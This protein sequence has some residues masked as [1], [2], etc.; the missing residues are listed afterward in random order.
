[1]KHILTI[2]LLLLTISGFSQNSPLVVAEGGQVDDKYLGIDQQFLI[3]DRLVSG[4]DL[5]TLTFDSIPEVYITAEQIFL[6]DSLTTLSNI[7]G[8]TSRWDIYNSGLIKFNDLGTKGLYMQ[9][10]EN[11]SI[12]RVYTTQGGAGIQ[13]LD[14]VGTGIT[15]YGGDI[16]VKPDEIWTRVYDP[17]NVTDSEI[18][19]GF[20]RIE[21]GVTDS[22]LISGLS[23]SEGEDIILAIDTAT[24][25]LYTKTLSASSG[26]INYTTYS[27]GS[28]SST[29]SRLG[30]LPTVVSNPGTG[31]YN[32]QVASGA[33]ILEIDF[34]GNDVN[35]NAGL[36][37]ITID[38]SANSRDRFFT[39]QT[40]Q[41]TTNG[42][43][44]ATA[45]ATNYTQ[46]SS[47]NV[48]TIQIS[49]LGGFGSTGYR[50]MLR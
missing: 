21:L 4:S 7:I 13:A 19:V 44:D 41:R 47:G 5:Y 2:L 30:G 36:L 8:S 40:I 43:V 24:N 15:Y 39:V 29:V 38:N 18:R 22:M 12:F 10:V 26:S 34:L 17:S 48:T 3:S 9:Q 11:D 37:T 28:V 25:K 27:S 1:M 31:S 16:S 46:S 42:Q 20:G 14:R 32:Y 49:N 45:T 50:L 23:F 35:L 6:T 33:H